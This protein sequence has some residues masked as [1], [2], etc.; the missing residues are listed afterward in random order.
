MNRSHYISTLIVYIK[1]ITSSEQILKVGKLNLVDLASSESIGRSRVESKKVR[2]ASMINQSLLTLG[3]FY[4]FESK[5]AR[6]LK[7]SLGGKIKTCI[8]AIISIV[9]SSQEESISTLDYT[10]HAKNIRN[11][12][13]AN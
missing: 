3:R 4:I 1:E 7:D 9:K 2:E 5:L 6:L 8:I 12:S 10:S 13:E 11:H